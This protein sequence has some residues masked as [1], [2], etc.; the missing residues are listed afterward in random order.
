MWYVA[1]DAMRET[2]R[3]GR[4]AKPRDLRCEYVTLGM[5]VGQVQVPKWG[6]CT[7]HTGNGGGGSMKAGGLPEGG[8]PRRGVACQKVGTRLKVGVKGPQSGAQRVSPAAWGALCRICL[9]PLPSQGAAQVPPRHPH[10]PSLSEDR[11]RLRPQEM[12]R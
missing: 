8:V 4:R 1:D 5:E 2:C 10:P 11:L 9:G 3:S 6:S 12:F 7:Y